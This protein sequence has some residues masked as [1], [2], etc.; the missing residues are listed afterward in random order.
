LPRFQTRGF[1]RQA[2]RRE[3]DAQ[4]EAMP[5][6]SKR[7]DD[8]QWLTNSDSP[9]QAWRSKKARLTRNLL[10]LLDESSLRYLIFHFKFAR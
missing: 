2:R 5:V 4:P 6:D 7:E 1:V 10:N 8:R 9:L 3:A